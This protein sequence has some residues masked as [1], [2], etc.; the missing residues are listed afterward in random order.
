[1]KH[2][3][4]LMRVLYF[5]VLFQVIACQSRLTQSPVQK[6]K[7]IMG[8]FV[9]IVVYDDDR[10]VA[11]IQRTIEQAFQEIERID[12]LASNWT[13]NSTV[14]FINQNAGKMWVKVEPELLEIIKQAQNISC[15]SKGAFDITVSPLIQLWHVTSPKA[16]LPARED[17]LDA[18]KRVGYNDILI[19]ADSIHFNRPDLQI[20]LGGIAKGFAVDRGMDVLVRHGIH[21]ALINAGGDFSAICSGLTAGKRKVWIKHPRDT[22]KLYGYFKMDDGSVATSG[23]Y[24]RYFMVDTVRYHHIIDPFTGYPASRSISVTIK[25][26]TAMM[27]DAL[28]TAVFILGPKEGMKLIN[29]LNDVDGV[30]IFE[31]D[32]KLQHIVSDNLKNSFVKS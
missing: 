27:A 6:M 14:A 19:K 8:T 11:E 9:E 18:V 16:S 15:I 7:L 32:H 5:F 31:R 4:R 17:I 28:A 23:D 26:Q 10:P 30:I 13:E 25:A 22:D 1:M 24:E 12:S 3:D 21:D 29:S 20:D 2:N